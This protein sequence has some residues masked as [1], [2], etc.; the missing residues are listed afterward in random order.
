MTMKNE[1]YVYIQFRI[2][3]IFIFEEKYKI[4]NVS[5]TFYGSLGQTLIK[6]GLSTKITKN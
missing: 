6:K 5:L 3:I 2:C 1:T 4:S